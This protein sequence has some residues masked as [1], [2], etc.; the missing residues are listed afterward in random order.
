MDE[1]DSAPALLSSLGMIPPWQ[2]EA[3]PTRLARDGYTMSLA[4]CVAVRGRPLTPA[5]VRPTCLLTLESQRAAWCAHALAQTRYTCAR[6]RYQQ[7]DAHECV[8]ECAG[9][10]VGKPTNTPF[11]LGKNRTLSERPFFEQYKRIICVPK[12]SMSVLQM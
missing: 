12:P 1:S 7:D 2:G 3:T 8:Y 11:P 4:L 5:I 9:A 6:P 10:C